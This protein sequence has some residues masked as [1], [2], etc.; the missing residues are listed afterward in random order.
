MDRTLSI[1]PLFNSEALDSQL[2][3]IVSL[4]Y[5]GTD[6]DYEEVYVMRSNY[7]D[8]DDHYDHVGEEYLA[9]RFTFEDAYEVYLKTCAQKNIALDAYPEVSITKLAPYTLN[10]ME[11]A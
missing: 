11:G 7:D 6:N 9:T 8:E 5:P 1:L 3:Y 4:R 2:C 10:Q